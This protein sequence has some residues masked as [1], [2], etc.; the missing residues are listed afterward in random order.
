MKKLS[1]KFTINYFKPDLKPVMEVELNER[2]IVETHD[3][4]GGQVTNEGI[5]RPEID[6]SIMN[7]ATGPIYINEVKK[8][9][10]IKI[11]IENIEIGQRG[12]MM[13]TKGLGVLGEDI[14]EPTTKMIPVE[15]QQLKFS[16][17]LSLPI[18]PMIG[19]IGVA[20]DK[21]KVH[22][23]VPGNHGGNLDTK[24]ITTG[25]SIYLPV[26]QEGALLA[27][28]DLHAAMGDG[29]LDGTGV[30]IDG[31]VTLSV[32]K[33][34][35]GQLLNPV[36]ESPSAFYFLASAETIEH[37]IKTASSN[38]VEHLMR[39]LTL[40]FEIAYRL[41]SA[42]CNIQISQVVNKLVTVRVKVPKELLP[43][44]FKG[45]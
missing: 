24:D 10:V 17:N 38:T 15:N 12:I 37:A 30:E 40:D 11:D 31:K 32:S 8:N 43:Q 41:L 14:H 22:T 35:D 39:E 42:Y 3:C 18:K 34:D 26:F 19:V 6:I 27:M 25:N 1:R 23:A 36:V 5:L 4:Y 33:V 13:L 28:G 16:E 20:T 2:F 7:L 44:L 21:E 9:D 45:K 29:E